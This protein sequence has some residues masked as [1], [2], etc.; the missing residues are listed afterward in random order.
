MFDTFFKTGRKALLRVQYA[1]SELVCTTC[2]DNDAHFRCSKAL[3][4]L[5]SVVHIESDGV[6][7]FKLERQVQVP[8]TFTPTHTANRCQSE[9]HCR[10]QTKIG[11][12]SCTKLTSDRCGWKGFQTLSVRVQTNI[13]PTWKYTAD[14]F[15][16][17]RKKLRGAKKFNL[18]KLFNYI[19]QRQFWGHC[20]NIWSYILATSMPRFW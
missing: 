16:W 4:V 9:H 5:H 19:G 15:P 20:V 8:P 14:L 12:R 17:K 3:M 2:G 10:F 18:T 6:M 7:K 11:G 1:L 13:S